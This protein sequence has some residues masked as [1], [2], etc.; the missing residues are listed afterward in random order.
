MDQRPALGGPI[1]ARWLRTWDRTPLK[2]LL[3]LM[4]HSGI[5]PNMMTTASL[6]PALICAFIL[7]QGYLTAAAGILLLAG[8]FDALDGELAQE[9]LL[10]V[11][12]SIRSPKPVLLS[13]QHFREQSITRITI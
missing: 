9:R 2:P 4:A 12:G 1:L 3:T 6:A 11:F 5:R 8:F 10:P 13:R 7:S